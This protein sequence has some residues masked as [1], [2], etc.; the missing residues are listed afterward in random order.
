MAKAIGSLKTGGRQKGTPN[1]RTLGFS[2]TLQSQGVDLLAEI[3]ESTKSLPEKERIGIYLNLLPYQ[4][5]KRK[6]TETVSLSL[7]EQIDQ[8]SKEEIHFIWKDLDSRLG[9]NS[10]PIDLTQEQLQEMKSTIENIL[11]LRKLEADLGEPDCV[12]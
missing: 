3:L 1:K 11:S 9:D 4:Y 12:V 6:P 2:E 8:L 7:L 5:P 10:A